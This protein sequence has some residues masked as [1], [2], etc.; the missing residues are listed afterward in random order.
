M[1]LHDPRS[2]SDDENAR[3]CALRSGEWGKWPAFISQPLVPVLYLVYPWI[4]VLASVLVLN[5]VWI[6]FRYRLASIQLATAGALFARLKWITIP[7]AAIVCLLHKEY[8]VAVLSLLTPII[9]PMLGMLTP[10]YGLGRL[11]R[12]FLKQLGYDELAE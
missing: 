1:L 9:M 4:W 12:V 2:F 6:P 10:F 8:F 7:V 5:A 11:Q 3:A